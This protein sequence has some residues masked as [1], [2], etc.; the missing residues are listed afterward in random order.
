MKPT[1]NVDYDTIGGMD[2]CIIAAL[3]A[4]GYIARRE[5]DRALDWTSK[6]D[7]KFFVKKSREAG[8]IVMGTKTLETVR[9]K[10]SEIS[11]YAWTSQ[12]EKV[13]EF[14]PVNIVPI[15]GTPAE[16]VAKAKQDGHTSL[17]ICGGTSVYTQ[18]M[19]SRLV[20]R[21]ILTLEP[22][23]F[24]DGLPLFSESMEAKLHLKEFHNLSNQ[25]KAFEYEV[26]YGA[27][28]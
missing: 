10:M 8:A 18:F 22:I 9:H 12:P 1:Q 21:L 7:T 17:A 15:S 2:V 28:T 11:V 6:E 16:I 4:D 24:G 25:V 19:K 23:V 5:N 20:N 14:V 13:K 26:E 27:E 3:S